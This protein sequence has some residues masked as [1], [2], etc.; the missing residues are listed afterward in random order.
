VQDGVVRGIETS[1]GPISAPT[2][3]NCA[4]AYSQDI[5]AMAGIELPNWA[6]RHEILITEPVAPGVCPCMLMSFS[7]NYYIQQRPHGSIICGM[8]PDGKPEDHENNTT[9]QFAEKMARILVK[10]LPRTRG[11][12]VARQWSG[13]YDMTPDA[14]PVI[15]ET[16]VKNF[17]HSTGYSGHGFMLAPVA[18]KILAQHIA[19]QKPDIDF[20]MLDYRRFARGEH[21]MESNVV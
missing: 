2:V 12:R 18:G 17:F 10:L 16:D 4:G 15:G 5:A 6:E 9:W 21:I 8:S 13:Q 7:G 20:S 11:I 14:Q 1:R 3:I 19:G